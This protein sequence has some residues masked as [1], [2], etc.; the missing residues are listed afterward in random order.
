MSQ[1]MNGQAFP[2]LEFAKVGGGS[3]ILPESLA[4][5]F[6]VILMYRGSWCPYCNAQLSAFQRAMDTLGALK[7]SVVALSVDNEL[8][9]RGT[10]EKHHITFPIGYG[11]D[12]ENVSNITGAYTN[13]EPRYLQSTDF[14]L[15]P[16]ST[17]LLAVYSSGAI[18]RLTPE[19][20]AV[21]IR[22][23]AASEST[24]IPS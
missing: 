4:G 11:A 23:R 14:I 12:A 3:L 13:A 8:A 24:N 5:R 20:V 18:G 1:L 16:D 15:S 21:F 22:H 6:G 17:V 7:I 10:I 19:D 9:A 2:H